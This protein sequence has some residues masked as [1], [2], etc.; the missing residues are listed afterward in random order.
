M[1]VLNVMDS[2]FAYAATKSSFGHSYQLAEPRTIAIGISVDVA[3]ML[4]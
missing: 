4:K 1:H 3:K 2:Y